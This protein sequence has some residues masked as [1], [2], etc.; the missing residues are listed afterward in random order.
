[1]SATALLSPVGVAAQLGISDHTARDLMRRGSIRSRNIA[2]P[3]CREQWRTLQ[4][5][6]DDYLE[7][8]GE[9]EDG[10]PP[11]ASVEQTPAITGAENFLLFNGSYKDYRAQRRPAAR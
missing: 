5:Y 1:M 3:G 11:I 10:L 4:R 6:I 7:A 9:R 2:R 8:F